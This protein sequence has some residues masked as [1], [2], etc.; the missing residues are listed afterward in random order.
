MPPENKEKYLLDTSAIFTLIED[1]KGA[2]EVERIL[3]E[4]RIILPFV[5][6]LEVYYISWKEKGEEIADR[7]YAMLKSLNAEFILS[8]DE[9][10]LMTAGRLKAKYN[11][12]LADALI[13]AC[14]ITSDAIL[15]HKDK[16]YEVLGNQVKQHILPYEK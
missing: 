6:L 7:R 11:L 10:T 9:P 15:V 8:L 3:R 13:A 14:A 16:D 2:D 1:E 12:P 4:K 5:V